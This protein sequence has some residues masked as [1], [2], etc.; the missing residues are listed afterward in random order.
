MHNVYL[1]SHAMLVR[2]K[3]LTSFV[4]LN[5]FALSCVRDGVNNKSETGFVTVIIENCPN[6]KSTTEMGGHLSQIDYSTISY[7][8]ASGD[9]IQYEPCESEKDTIFIPTYNGYAE[10]MH[11]YKAIEFDTFLLKD[12][13]TVYITYDSQKRPH[14]TSSTSKIYTLLYNLLYS[15]DGAVQSRGYHIK[16]ILTNQQFIGPYRYY[17]DAALQKKYPSLKQVFKERYVDLDSLKL[18]YEQ[19]AMLCNSIIDSLCAS[20]AIELEYKNYLKRIVLLTDPVTPHDVVKSDSL[21]HY[22]SNY[23]IAQKYREGEDATILFDEIAKD[24]TVTEV[25]RRGLLKRLTNRIISGESGWRPYPDS[26]VKH[27]ISDYFSITG[28]SSF[29][30][31]QTN[32]IPDAEIQPK[33]YDALLEDRNG[34]IWT[35]KEIIDNN[36]GYLIYIDVWASWCAPC[37]AEMPFSKELQKSVSNDKIVFLFLST[38]T[39][40]IAWHEAIVEEPSMKFTYRFITSDNSFIKGMRINSIPRYIIVDSNG[41]IINTNADRPSSQKIETDLKRLSNEEQKTD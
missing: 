9:L 16:T 23:I 35:L 31:N 12:G 29:E 22:I 4:I 24:T 2:V 34:Q 3:L 25:A 5:C 41:H 39:D 1:A 17:K 14:L 40:S 27:Y 33:L 32:R 13:D 21:L 18:V 19:F 11:L 10:I 7:I 37:R 8:D 36:Q 15:M 26:A 28:D 38:D 6:Q 20:S 30:H